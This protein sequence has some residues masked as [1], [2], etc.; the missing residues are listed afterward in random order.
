MAVLAVFSLPGLPVTSF[1]GGAS[2][3]KVG[4]GWCLRA[5]GSSPNTDVTHGSKC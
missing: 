3:S 2:Q 1:A 5:R 4:Y